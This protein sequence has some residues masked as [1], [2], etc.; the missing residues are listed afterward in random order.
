MSNYRSWTLST[1]SGA[2]GQGLM[3][4]RGLCLAALQMVDEAESLSL[5]GWVGRVI[6]SG[7]AYPVQ[8]TAEAWPRG[9]FALEV[10]NPEKGAALVEIWEA[11][12]PGA[13]ARLV[14]ISDGTNTGTGELVSYR[15]LPIPAG[16]TIR[17]V[18]NTA[19]P[20]LVL[21][22]QDRNSGL[23]ISAHSLTENRRGPSRVSVS[24][25]AVSDCTL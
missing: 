19:A 18:I 23:T 20:F 22:I 25:S 8:G 1:E 14:E 3:G 9:P 6:D 11:N 5:T 15:A 17:E 10:T 13:L 12:T 2:L 7:T 16:S 4:Y 21:T 24:L